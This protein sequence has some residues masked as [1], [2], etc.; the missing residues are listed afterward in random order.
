MQTE[1]KEKTDNKTKRAPTASFMMGVVALVLLAVGYQTALFIHS[2]AVERVVAGRDHPDTVFVYGTSS[3]SSSGSSTATSS[4]SSTAT[5]SGSYADGSSSRHIHQKETYGRSRGTS[6]PDAGSRY[7]SADDAS[8]CNSGYSQA[9]G[10]TSLPEGGQSHVS[11]CEEN[12]ARESTGK[13]D[14]GG[15]RHENSAGRRKS[16]GESTSENGRQEVLEMVRKNASH[17][18]EVMAIRAANPPRPAE[19]FDFDPNS[20][21]LDDLVRLGFS[22]IQAASIVNYRNKGG[23]FR[24]KSDFARSFVVSEEMFSRLEPYI[25]IPKLDLNRADS[26]ALDALPGIGP[27]FVKK[28]IAYRKSLRG[29]SY[30]GQLMDIYHFDQEKYDALSDLVTAGPVAPYPIWTLPADSLRAH[31]YIG[32]YSANGIVLYR[33][34]HPKDQWTLDGLAQAGVL[35][36]ENVPKLKRC[37]LAAP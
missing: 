8:D 29:Y 37:H 2:A 13:G 30:P 1:M 18:E 32:S 19:L 23:R 6:R 15:K 10:K 16:G 9:C 26:A 20:A 11:Y 22:A 34:H 4:V 7:S 25:A 14:Y 31:P 5:S 12:E 27:Y 35:R 33:K 3:G 28:I 24:R 36:P 21:S 17:S